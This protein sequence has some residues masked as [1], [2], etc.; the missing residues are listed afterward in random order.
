MG[1]QAS[2]GR[3]R[4]IILSAPSGTGKTTIARAVAASHPQVEVSVS[5]TT[6]RPRPEEK[7]GQDYF[8]V[9]Q[10]S[11]LDMI[12]ND[13][14]LEH[15]EVFDHCYGTSHGAVE[16]QLADGISVLLVIDWRGA[17]LVRGRFEDVLSIFFVP[18]S[19]A[20]L[21]R[22]LAERGQDSDIA[23][24]RRLQEALEEVRHHHEY[25]HVI[26]NDHFETAVEEC[27]KLIF[28]AV[29]PT[30]GRYFDPT[31]FIAT[32]KNGTLRDRRDDD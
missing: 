16:R 24:K 14:F 6:R 3:G 20:V 2:G 7:H 17:R 31:S 13:Q 12:E 4:L 30:S 27:E 15:A 19:Y 10:Q 1:Q 25:D 22:R 26:V 28:S 11:F 21:E 8:F 23:M 29:A 5:H 9:D 18:P 32:M